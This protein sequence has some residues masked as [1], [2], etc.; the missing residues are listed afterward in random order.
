MPDDLH[1]IIPD[2]TVDDADRL[3]SFLTT[4]LDGHVV[5]ENRYDDD[6]IQHARAR[7]GDSVIMLNEAGR[8]YEANCSQLH[9]CVADV[10][11]VF[12]AALREGATEVMAPN[13]RPHG[14]RMAG[15]RDPCD[16]L[17]WIAAAG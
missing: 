7:V 5:T 15:F 6:R 13:W 9:L 1:S 2:F 4:A 16:N 3:I 8:G 10:D 11:T 14:D 17:W 12:A